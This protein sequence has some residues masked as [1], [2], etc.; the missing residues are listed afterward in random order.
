M[1]ANA[2]PSTIGKV[3]TILLFDKSDSSVQ[4]IAGSTQ[5]GT[6]EAYGMANGRFLFKI[7]GLQTKSIDLNA[8]DVD[9]FIHEEF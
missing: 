3:V 2:I 1:P 5:T 7:K 4:K 9:L 6:L 8:L